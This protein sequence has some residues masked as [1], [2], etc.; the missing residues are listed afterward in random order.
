VFSGQ[1]KDITSG[2]EANLGVLGHPDGKFETPDVADNELRKSCPSLVCELKQSKTA[3]KLSLAP[4]S[5]ELGPGAA[6]LETWAMVHLF[7]APC[8]RKQTR[9]FE[10]INGLHTV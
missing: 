2:F 8:R 3:A 9:T 4:I 10:D 5:R 6:G 1:Y 7:S